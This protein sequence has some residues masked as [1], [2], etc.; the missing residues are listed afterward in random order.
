MTGNAIPRRRAPPA[1]ITKMRKLTK[2][3]ST[4]I[5]AARLDIDSLY[6]EGRIYTLLNRDTL[7]AELERIPPAPPKCMLAYLGSS[8]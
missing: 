5:E 4:P 7:L 2:T 6:Q 3:E 8:R 1:Q